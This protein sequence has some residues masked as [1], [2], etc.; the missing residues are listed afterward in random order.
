MWRPAWERMPEVDPGCFGS[1]RPFQE[2]ELKSHNPGK[3]E[4]GRG[5]WED[6]S[7]R[8]EGPKNPW[9]GGHRPQI[10]SLMKITGEVSRRMWNGEVYI[11]I[12]CIGAALANK[13]IQV[14]GVRFCVWH[15]D[16]TLCAHRP[17]S[18]SLHPFSFSTPSTDREFS[19]L[20]NTASIYESEFQRMTWM[21]DLK[22]TIYDLT[23]E[24][25]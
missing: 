7:E 24:E 6:R 19:E 3:R 4:S 9:V 10:L 21:R 25:K 15:L 23:E 12:K 14:W 13:I 5:K 16:S 18:N 20:P 2:R 22:R 8:E 1:I 11:F 17:K